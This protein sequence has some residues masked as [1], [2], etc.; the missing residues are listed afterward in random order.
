MNQIQKNITWH[1][2]S[3]IGDL[4]ALIKDE[5][6]QKVLSMINFGKTL[7]RIFITKLTQEILKNFNYTDSID[8][9]R[10]DCSQDRKVFSVIMFYFPGAWDKDDSKRK[11][12][13]YLGISLWDNEYRY[14]AGLHKA[15]CGIFAPKNGRTDIENKIAGFKYLSDNYGWFFDQENMCK[16]NGYNYEKEMY[17]YKKLDISNL[18]VKELSEKVIVDLSLIN[19]YLKTMREKLCQD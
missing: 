16:W 4:W 13:C 7:E 14:H 2:D 12:L 5:E 6:I 1:S 15:Q 18:T 19:F 8:K 10:I 9:I 17:L 11:D 3:K